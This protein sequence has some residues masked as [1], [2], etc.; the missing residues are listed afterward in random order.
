MAMMGADIGRQETSPVDVAV[1]NWRD[2]IDSF[3][4]PCLLVFDSYYFSAATL[5]ALGP[6]SHTRPCKFL[7]AVTKNKFRVC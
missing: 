1:K 2:V 6:G 4:L 3:N 5:E 7:G